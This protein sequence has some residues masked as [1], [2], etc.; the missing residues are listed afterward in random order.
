MKKLFA[1]GDFDG[2]G[3]EDTIFQ[4]N[5]SR[6][7]RTEIDNS[8]DPTQNE[9]DT[10]V[11][12]FVD[13]DADVYLTTHKNNQDTLHVGPAQGLYC[14]INIGDINADG[15]DE[16]ALVIDYL[17]V[18]NVN[19]CEI[20]SLCNNKWTRLKQFGV[21]EDAFNVTAAKTPIFDSIK[22]YLEKQNGTWVYN[23]YSQGHDGAKEVGE[24]LALKLDKCK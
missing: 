1:R 21:H 14:L 5:Y 10:V 9:W 18:S 2:D 12:W 22:G 3:G 4:H 20:Y 15:K 23:D 17:D 24:M 6:L 11:Q 16:I 7:T 19:S 13:R 8:P